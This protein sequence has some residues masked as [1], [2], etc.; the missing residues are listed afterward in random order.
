MATEHEDLGQALRAFIDGQVEFNRT[1]LHHFDSI[2]SDVS[3]LKTEA[4]NRFQ[5]L[6]N[7]ISEIKGGH[8][9]LMATQQPEL[10]AERLGF[11]YE[12][13]ISVGELIDMTREQPEVISDSGERESFLN[14]DLVLK[15][16][17]KDNQLTNYI[18][19]EISY[20]GHQR[21]TERALRNSGYLHQFTGRPAHAAIASTVAR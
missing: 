6:A 17:D 19:V 14:A 8:A 16:K 21:D 12:R 10:V 2:R 13:I 4:D 18:A 5:G 20:T 11:R 1:I 7:N 3:E 9:Y 15:V